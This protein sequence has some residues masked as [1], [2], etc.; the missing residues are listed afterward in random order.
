MKGA[1]TRNDSDAAVGKEQV[2]N[3]RSEDCFP[4]DPCETLQPPKAEENKAEVGSISEHPFSAT[5]KPTENNSPVKG[6][7]A[8]GKRT[9]PGNTAEAATKSK[10]KV[11]GRWSAEEHEKFVQ[12]TPTRTP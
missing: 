7:K 4:K 2:E 6:G 3:H 12:G 9:L 10:T 1:E 5:K 8:S 11:P